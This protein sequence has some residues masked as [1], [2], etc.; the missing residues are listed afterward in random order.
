MAAQRNV[1]TH[2]AHAQAAALRQF[3]FD[4]TNRK[5]FILHARTWTHSLAGIRFPT[6]KDSTR[7]IVWLKVL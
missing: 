6:K 2:R 1:N 3:H 4:L 7:K 5:S